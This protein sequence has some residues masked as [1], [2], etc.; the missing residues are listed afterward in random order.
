M[1]R[2]MVRMARDQF[3][4][5]R[6]PDQQQRVAASQEHFNM[7]TVNHSPLNFWFS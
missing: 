2:A 3:E 1:F 6:N 4:N 5:D 7:D